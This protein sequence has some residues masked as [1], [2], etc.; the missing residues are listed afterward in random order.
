[1]REGRRRDDDRGMTTQTVSHAAPRTTWKVVAGLVEAAASLAAW[2]AVGGLLVNKLDASLA[3][4]GET[5]RVRPEHVAAYHRWLTV[6][7]LAVVVSFAAARLRDSRRGRSFAWHGFVLLV[8]VAA[9]VL[10]QVSIEKPTEQPAPR[11]HVACY[12]GGT[13]VECPGG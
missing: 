11:H 4:F 6:L 10:L 13:S 1:M 3:F 2:V 5:A 8:A 12:S 9:A 7:V